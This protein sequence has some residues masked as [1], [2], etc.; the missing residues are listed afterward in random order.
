MLTLQICK[1]KNRRPPWHSDWH[2]GVIWG[3]LCDAIVAVDDIVAAS[4]PTL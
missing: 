1:V 3:Q 4:I 2:T